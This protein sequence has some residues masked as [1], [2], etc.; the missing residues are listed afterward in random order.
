MSR[1]AW[2]LRKALDQVRAGVK[3]EAEAKKPEIKEVKEEP[4]KTEK[5]EEKKEEPKKPEEKKEEPKKPE[6]K[7]EEKKEEATL[8]QR[9]GGEPAVKKVV[10]DWFELTANDPKVDLA[11]GG[12]FQPTPEQVDNLKKLLVAQISMASG[13]PLKY[14]G[15]SMKETHKGM[16]I[17]AAEFDAAAANLKKVLE[18]HK[19]PAV[20]I[21]DL[22]KIVESTRKD[23]V[24]KE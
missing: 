11:R 23:I 17:T 9:L 15:R 16:E 5:I 13:G 7:K 3:P 19:V 18:D 6:D 20:E 10:D 24:E 4:K 2:I 21:Q 12:K 22:L 8:W 1:R 14:T